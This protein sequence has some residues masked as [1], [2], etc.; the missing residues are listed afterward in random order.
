MILFGTPEMSI[1]GAAYDYKKQDAA[2]PSLASV[3]LPLASWMARAA[4]SVSTL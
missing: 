1:S 3:F 4:D 2:L